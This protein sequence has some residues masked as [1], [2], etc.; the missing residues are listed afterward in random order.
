M[1]DRFTTKPVLELPPVTTQTPTKAT[2]APRLYSKAEILAAL[3][4]E[5]DAIGLA[6]MSVKHGIA[7]QQISDVLYGR[8]NLSKLMIKKLK[9]TLFEFY[10]KSEGDK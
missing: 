1:P 10:A 8:A 5:K 7:P 4:A 6:A 2:A 9:L 3:K